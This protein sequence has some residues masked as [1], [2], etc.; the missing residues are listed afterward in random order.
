M[1]EIKIGIEENALYHLQEQMEDKNFLKGV[2]V[3]E[4]I[5]N[6]KKISINL[7]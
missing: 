1:I 4:L 2:E 5:I 3:A 7:E 6:D